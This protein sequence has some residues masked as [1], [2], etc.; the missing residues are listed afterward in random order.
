MSYW[1]EA[2]KEDLE[3]RDEEV[4]IYA[5]YDDGGN[6]Y[7]AIPLDRFKDFLK[8]NKEKLYDTEKA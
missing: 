8:E 2:E 5:G 7:V 1:Y 4:H 6:R 3:I